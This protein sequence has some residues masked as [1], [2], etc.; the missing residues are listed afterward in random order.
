MT[1]HIR[2]IKPSCIVNCIYDLWISMTYGGP[3]PT[4]ELWNWNS[5]FMSRS[6]VRCTLGAVA[7]KSQ[8]WEGCNFSKKVLATKKKTKLFAFWVT[9]KNIW[10][11]LALL[12]RST[13]WIF[14]MIFRTSFETRS[15]WGGTLTVKL[16]WHG[17]GML[18]HLLAEAWVLQAYLQESETPVNHAQDVFR[19][20]LNIH[21]IWNHTDSYFWAVLGDC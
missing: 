7:Q 2:F 15:A 8:E 6:N 5:M 16:S 18:T 13:F 19:N 11:S 12:V 21:W 10:K 20:T 3:M 17:Q 9:S 14:P 4:H 1:Y